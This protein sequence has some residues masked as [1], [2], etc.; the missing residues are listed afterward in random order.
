MEYD[1]VNHPKHYTSSGATCSACNH[2]I[3]CIDVVEHHNFNV[4][5]VIK[6]CWRAGLKADGDDK[7][8]LEDLRKAQWYLAREIARLGGKE[9]EFKREANDKAKEAIQKMRRMN[10]AEFA[11]LFSAD[12][13]RQDIEKAIAQ[14]LMDGIDVTD[15][16]E[17]IFEVGTAVVDEHGSTGHVIETRRVADVFEARVLWDPGTKNFCNPSWEVAASLALP[18]FPVAVRPGEQP[19]PSR[20]IPA[21]LLETPIG[22]GGDEVES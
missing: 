8:H 10:Q 5:N 17:A 4:G 20:A 15:P 21:H 6:Y 9:D 2:T 16:P 12:R 18:S 3:E 13:R 7:K 19:A 1:S 22:P 14:L 11:S